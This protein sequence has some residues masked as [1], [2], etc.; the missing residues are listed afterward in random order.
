MS[1]KLKGSVF[2]VADAL[3]LV[4]ASAFRIT[5]TYVYAYKYKEG[6]K[7]L[8]LVPAR[9]KHANIKNHWDDLVDPEP[10]TPLANTVIGSIPQSYKAAS[11]LKLKDP[12][13]KLSDVMSKDGQPDDE[14]E[15]QPAMSKADINQTLSGGVSLAAYLKTVGFDDPSKQAN[16]LK[17]TQVTS[18]LIKQYGAKWADQAYALGFD[19]P[20]KKHSNDAKAAAKILGYLQGSPEFHALS[21]LH[22]AGNDA[23][24]L[25]EMLTDDSTEDEADAAVELVTKVVEAAEKKGL[26]STKPDPNDDTTTI[27]TF[28]AG[29]IKATPEYA[30]LIAASTPASPSPPAATPAPVV[31]PPAPVPAPVP[32]AAP[33]PPPTPAPLS[34]LVGDNVTVT[35]PTKDWLASQPAGTTLV[36]PMGVQYR[37]KPVG[38]SWTVLDGSGKNQWTTNGGLAKAMDGELLLVFKPGYEPPAP[39]LT[40]SPAPSPAP[41]SASSTATAPAVAPAV[42]PTAASGL[43]LPAIPPLTTLKSMGSAKGALGGIHDKFFVTDGSGNKFLFKPSEGSSALA[44]EAY[45]K[46]AAAA[47]GAENVIPVVSG[48]VAGLGFGSVQPMI[49]NVKTDLSKVDIGTLTPSQLDDLMRERVMDW[50]LSSHDT[51]AANFLMMQDGKIVGVDK[52]QAFKLIGQ[53]KL[54][55]GY[56]PNPTPQIYTD[57]FDR[58]KKKK[59]NL[60]IGAM[61]PAIEG[62]EAISD[63][64]W[65]AMASG[66]VAANPSVKAAILDRKKNLRKDLEGFLTKLLQERGDIGKNDTFE[67][68]TKTKKK[69]DIGGALP[70][71]GSSGIPPL[72]SLPAFSELKATGNKVPGA[73]GSSYFYKDA[74]GNDYVVKTAVTRSG[75]KVSEPFRAE[76]QS[77]AAQVG[78]LIKL[79]KVVPIS[80]V[81]DMGNGFAGTIQ[82]WVKG[83]TEIGGTSPSQLKDSEKADIAD[84]HVVDWLTSQ[85][86]THGGNLLRRP[87]G[88]IV[89]IDKEQGFKYRLPNKIAPGGDVL[90]TDFWPNQTLGG[91]EPYYNKFWRAFADGSMSFDPMSMKGAIDRAESIS[92]ADYT[93]LLQSYAAAAPFAGDAKKVAE[94]IDA[95]LQRKKNLR[96]DF[97]TFI[98]GLYEKRTKKKGTFSFAGGG[99]Q[100]QGAS[101]A[102]SP[103][104][105]AS[106]PVAAPAPIAAPSPPEPKKKKPDVGIVMSPAAKGVIGQQE[107]KLYEP[108]KAALAAPNPTPAGFP[109]PPPNMMWDTKGADAFNADHL[110]KFKDKSETVGGSKTALTADPEKIY[111]FQNVTA[112]NL[113]KVL[114][115]LGL[116]YKPVT[117][118]NSVAVLLDSN[119][120]NAAVASKKK[121]SQ[122]VP[123]PAAVGSPSALPA[124]PLPGQLKNPE[125]EPNVEEIA[126]LDSDKGVGYGKSFFVDGGAVEQQSLGVQRR[127]DANGNTYYRFA[128]RVR[129]PIW[130]NFSGGTS[131]NLVVPKMTYDAAS[132]SWKESS[133]NLEKRTGFKKWNN[134][135]SSLHLGQQEPGKGDFSFRG[136]VFAAVYPKLGQNP[137]E[138]LQ[139]MLNAVSPDFAKQVLKNPTAEE[140]QAMAYSAILYNIDPQAS[141]ELTEKERTPDTLR[142]KIREGALKTALY[143]HKA[144]NGSLGASKT[145]VDALKGKTEAQL[146]AIL[147]SNGLTATKAD[148][149]L[150]QAEEDMKNVRFERTGIDRVSPVIPGRS[151]RLQELGLTHLQIGVGNE[152]EHVAALLKTGPLGI[153]Q[154]TFLNGVDPFGSSYEADIQTGCGDYLCT[155]MKTKKTA[156]EWGSSYGNYQ[157]VLDPSELDRLDVFT[158]EADNF[159]TCSPTSSGGNSLD[160]YKAN[161]YKYRLPL[162]ARIVAGSFE[163]TLR[164]GIGLQKVLKVACQSDSERSSLIQ[165]LQKDGITGVN[166]MNAS[167]LVTSSSGVGGGGIYNKLLKPAGY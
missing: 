165:L 92:D 45:A 160:S 134:G 148:E 105:A 163:T 138:A 125:A 36:S 58:F 114:E 7:A 1:E 103:A 9:I 110:L 31:L 146:R 63:D 16:L 89:G 38:T 140:K 17:N 49:P 30:A 39:A 93:K 95:G 19:L 44:G 78:N 139:E 67:F 62:V 87:D 153:V 121:V 109:P 150:A 167:D 14:P 53:D 157:L 147:E 3:L 6:N 162:E 35:S 11:D 70:S 123:T 159:G 127:V 99:W 119:A 15:P 54:D 23:D 116:P 144:K 34:S 135:Q 118:T 10:G 117:S 33:P 96:K 88:A 50:A 8:G 124:V 112:D 48:N 108:V 64:A 129:E 66:Y 47:V 152:P 55:I 61:L 136:M 26:V 104:A 102:P 85:H 37:K 90:S 27:V 42:A 60:N 126:E 130:K 69:K 98:S 57:L 72:P 52:E 51:K 2:T 154:R 79:G 28:N 80:V 18:V 84:E 12:T 166:G 73:T 164:R 71:V 68:E 74:L 22:T 97:E 161:R 137:S 128:F 151:K 86:D 75:P 158:S 91:P 115:Q 5:P 120:W 40:P 76:S 21:L 106:I 107:V 77:I 56:K 101:K 82:A 25:A 43:G 20:W 13:K 133:S 65:L 113:Q 132:D 142:Q 156:G 4:E 81:P 59:L 111:K 41:S 149:A 94:F 100:E 122:L 145:E 24:A 46:M 143:V 155:R 141:D 131:D 29:K 32:V 83:A